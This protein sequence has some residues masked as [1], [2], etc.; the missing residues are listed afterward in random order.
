MDKRQHSVTHNKRKYRSKRSLCTALGITYST[1]CNDM[2]ASATLDEAVEKGLEIRRER[3]YL[4]ERGVDNLADYVR[5]V[6][7]EHGDWVDYRTLIELY[8]ALSTKNRTQITQE[9]LQL[10]RL[11]ELFR[12]VGE[13]GK[14]AWFKFRAEKQ[15]V[16][17][18]S[19]RTPTRRAGIPLSQKLGRIDDW[20]TQ[21]I[22]Q[23]P[24]GWK[25][26]TALGSV[27]V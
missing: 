10:Y 24:W 17:H 5:S 18:S 8:P 9:L 6:M 16:S 13:S 19:S 15:A 21:L 22:H 11:G 26:G 7:Q 27:V 25:K 3:A 23:H 1:L 2:Q 14:G 4:E 12:D 20:T